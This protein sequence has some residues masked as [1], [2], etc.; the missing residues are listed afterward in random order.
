LHLL[1]LLH[2]L[3]LGCFL[4]HLPHWSCSF[5]HP[6][7]IAHIWLLIHLLLE[8]LHG[9]PLLG[10]LH[11]HNVIDFLGLRLEITSVRLPGCISDTLGLPVVGLH[12]SLGLS[13]VSSSR[14]LTALHKV[15]L[16]DKRSVSYLGEL[17]TLMR[18]FKLLSNNSH[19]FVAP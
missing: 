8:H 7:L 9:C 15:V 10:N 1:H 11:V 17:L 5:L 4:F 18:N 13:C 2:R 19:A 16:L 12:D 3:H 14:L 6:H